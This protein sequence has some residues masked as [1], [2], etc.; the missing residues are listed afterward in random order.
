MKTPQQRV[1][2][3]LIVKIGANVSRECKR[4]AEVRVGE[5]GAR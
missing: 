3:T 4:G 5:G 2:P 1:L